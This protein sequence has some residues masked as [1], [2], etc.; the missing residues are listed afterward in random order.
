MFLIKRTLVL[1]LAITVLSV[2][3]D[4]NCLVQNTAH[5]PSNEIRVMDKPVVEVEKGVVKTYDDLCLCLNPNGGFSGSSSVNFMKCPS[6]A[7]FIKGVHFTKCGS[8]AI[9]TGIDCFGL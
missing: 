2:M 4:S 9:P 8:R 6:A 7:P 5:K 3:V 1:Y